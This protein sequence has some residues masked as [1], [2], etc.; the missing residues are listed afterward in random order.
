MISELIAYESAL[1]FLIEFTSQHCFGISVL[2]VHR[3][4]I[5]IAIYCSSFIAFLRATIFLFFIIFFK[6]MYSLS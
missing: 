3:S 1:S 2:M 6:F 4:S 5:S